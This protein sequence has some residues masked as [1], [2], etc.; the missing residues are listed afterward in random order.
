[1]LVNLMGKPPGAVFAK[2]NDADSEFHVGDVKYHTGEA[3]TLTFEQV[4][5]RESGCSRTLQCCSEPIRCTRSTQVAQS[6]AAHIARTCA[7]VLPQVAGL[8][9]SQI[10]FDVGYDNT[11]QAGIA[12]EVRISIAPN[13]SHLE[14]V[15][16]VVLGLVR[17]EQVKIFSV[18]F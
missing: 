14:A 5:H 9:T 16:P 6:C 4:R 15:S 11:L 10:G 8:D 3:G 7:P 18:F 12:A 1:M 17:A 2:M 13:P